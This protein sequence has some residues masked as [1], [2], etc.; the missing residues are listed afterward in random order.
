MY[1]LI[2]A[3]DFGRVPAARMGEDIE[4]VVY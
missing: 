3:E 1:D 4:K 2:T